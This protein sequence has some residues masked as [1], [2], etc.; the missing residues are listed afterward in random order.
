MSE[1]SIFRL[2]LL[3]WTVTFVGAFLDMG[4]RGGAFGL[5]HFLLWQA[6]A[7]ILAVLLFIYGRRFEKRS[8]QRVAS[9]VPGILLIGILIA[10]ALF[11]GTAGF[12]TDGSIDIG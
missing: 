7:S 3:A 1:T 6:V 4:G 12:I 8:V 2:G 11:A 10:A 9:R 5:S